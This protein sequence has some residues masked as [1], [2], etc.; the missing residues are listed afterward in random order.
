MLSSLLKKSPKIRN[1]ARHLRLS[2]FGDLGWSRILDSREVHENYTD[3]NPNPPK[4][5]TATSFG[6]ELSMPILESLVSASLV[7]RGAEVHVLLCDG[8]SACQLCD[9]TRYPDSRS[10]ALRGIP[11][12]TCKSCFK[13]G[14][15]IYKSLGLRI[16][17]LSDFLAPCDSK[18][19]E[20]IASSV[21][22]EEIKSLCIEGVAVGEHAIAGT[23]RFFARA[24][25][26]DEPYG[27]DVLRRYLRSSILVAI[28][29]ERLL[30]QEDYHCV[31]F[32]H[33]IYVPQ[34]VIG[35]VCRKLSVRVVN[36]NTAYKKKSFIFS[37]HDTYHHT[38]MNEP[39]SS[40]EN[41]S[42]S[43]ELKGKIA[44]YIS[45]RAV[46]HDDWIKF[47]SSTKNNRE[48]IIAELGISESKPVIGMLT[49]V[50]WDAQ[51][52]FQENAFPNMFAWITE[53]IQYF[54]RRQDLQLLIRVHPAEITGHLKSR[55]P[56]VDEINRMFPMLTG[57][58]FIIGPEN[59]INTYEA[60]KL[61]DSVLIYGT[62][63]GVELASMGIPVIVAG[64]AWVRNKGITTDIV[65]VEQ[66]LR[67]LEA[68]P[69]GSRLDEGTRERALKYAFHFFNRRMIPLSSIHPTNGKPPF[70][71]K[72]NSLAELMDGYDIG[73][74]IVCRG[75]L[76][77]DP[78]IYPAELL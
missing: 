3:N 35:E 40:W 15:K 39:I 61:C 37:H 6:G 23:C 38:M 43:P 68:L 44:S 54:I 31:F 19:A 16:H 11:P 75:I 74:D 53:T 18:Y 21:D 57:N 77:G 26:E 71:F 22:S 34:G 42:L 41:L 4:V 45:S 56:V 14:E 60:M 28:A 52:H 76:N 70:I 30:R 1:L 51:L 72:V 12:S 17:R 25:F 10:F 58:I 20:V 33:G 67:V 73:L 2:L 65:S 13:A 78:F 36:W 69:L 64:E 48:Q 55:Q 62:K 49:N 5:L 63:M 66:Y 50:A 46:G 47:N 32:N 9:S 7:E 8:I 59:D 27:N 24:T 29:T